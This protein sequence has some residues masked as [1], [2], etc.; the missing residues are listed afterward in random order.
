[1][2]N[3]LRVLV[4]V[5]VVVVVAALLESGLSVLDALG[6]VTVSA[7]AA[8]QISSWLEQPASARSGGTA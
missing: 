6:L 3:G 1:M 8:T 4:F 5:V 7:G 2:S